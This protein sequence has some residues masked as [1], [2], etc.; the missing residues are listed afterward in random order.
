MLIFFNENAAP[1]QAAQADQAAL[2][3]IAVK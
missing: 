3:G 2:G 1:D